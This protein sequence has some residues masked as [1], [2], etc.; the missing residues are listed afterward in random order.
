MVGGNPP[1]FGRL[2]LVPTGLECMAT[3]LVRGFLKETNIFNANIAV[4]ERAM[5]TVSN[6]IYYRLILV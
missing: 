5:K 4:I 6:L 2:S 1:V 3:A